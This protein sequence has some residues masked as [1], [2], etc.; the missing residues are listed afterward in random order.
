M[1][2]MRF[3]VRLNLVDD[4]CLEFISSNWYSHDSRFN[5]FMQ[6]IGQKL[7]LLH[8]ILANVTMLSCYQQICTHIR[9]ACGG[10]NIPCVV[11]DLTSDLQ[12]LLASLPSRWKDEF[13]CRTSILLIYGKA[14]CHG[15]AFWGS[16]PKDVFLPQTFNPG[17]GP[18]YGSFCHTSHCN[19]F[20]FLSFCHA[21]LRGRW[22]KAAF[23][24]L[25][26]SW[27]WLNI[28]CSCCFEIWTSAKKV[29]LQVLTTCRPFRH[30]TNSVRQQNRSLLF[31]T[32]IT[33]AVW[34]H[35]WCMSDSRNG[36][37]LVRW[38]SCS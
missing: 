12:Y 8:G 3:Y 10:L 33:Y 31:S 11:H 26:L 24:T 1:S 28:H 13:F 20:V 29:F 38:S 22:I 2:W 35:T 27:L 18:A 6:N 9:H 25:P 37:T 14:R 34:S 7:I 4:V 32:E 5:V 21:I 16:S 17:Y 19:C 15:R 23:L 30:I 36:Q